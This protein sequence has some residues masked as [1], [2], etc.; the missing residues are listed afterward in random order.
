M[1]SEAFYELGADSEVAPQVQLGYRYPGCREPARIGRRARFHSGAV[2]YADTVI[3]DHFSCGHNA[4]IRA[5]CTIG[6]RVVI[7]HGSTLEGRVTIGTGVKIMAHVYIPS[8]TTIGN[9][10]FIGPGTNLLNAKL[11]M[12]KAGV[13]GPMIGNHVVI[14]G[15]VT[16]GPGVTIG[17]NA[18]I[19]AG[20]VVMKDVPPNSLALGCPAQVRPLPAEFGAGNDPAQIF[21]G[22]DLWDQRPNPEPWPEGFDPSAEA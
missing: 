19:A 5:E 10:V 4:T 1:S 9:M 11:P 13:Q 15:G 8:T 3:G 2:V 16:I 7:L 14:G 6:D 17:D 21:G 18:F 22:A 20:A 12:R